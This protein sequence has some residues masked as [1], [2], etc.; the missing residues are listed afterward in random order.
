MGHLNTV[1][2]V[3]LQANLLRFTV[4]QVNFG[5]RLF[6]VLWSMITS[7][8]HIMQCLLNR[9]AIT[10]VFSYEHPYARDILFVGVGMCSALPRRLANR[11]TFDDH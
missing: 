10:I 6:I 1:K 9:S 3:V 11:R 2:R 5:D 4:A 8:R 7:L